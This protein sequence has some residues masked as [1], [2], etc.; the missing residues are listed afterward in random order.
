MATRNEA[1]KNT[2]SVVLPTWKDRRIT[3]CRRT[4]VIVES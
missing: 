2:F 3:Q 1:K 4:K